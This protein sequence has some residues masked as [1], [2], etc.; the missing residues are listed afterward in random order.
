LARHAQA[1]VAATDD[2]HA[3]AAKARRQGAEGILI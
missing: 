2:E 1:D 3:L